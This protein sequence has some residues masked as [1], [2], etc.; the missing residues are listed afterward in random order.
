MLAVMIQS[1]E[2]VL[3]LF[4]IGFVGYV[5]DRKGW[6]SEDAKLMLPRLLTVI[7]LPPYLFHHVVKT[8]S[9]DDLIHLIYGVFVPAL[10]LALTALCAWLM[11][12]FMKKPEGRAGIFQ[13]GI[14]TSNTM[15]IGLPVNVALF[16]EAAIP[17]VLLYFF[18]NTTFF[19]TL[20]NYLIGR[21]G[22]EPRHRESI[23]SLKTL[24]RIISPPFMGL[25]LGLGSVF[26]DVRLPGF[27]MDS[28]GLI[29]GITAPLA[30]LFIGITMAGVNFRQITID[31]DVLMLL[32]GRFVISPATIILI[33]LFVDIPPLMAK[34]FIIQSSLPMVT[35]AVLL[36][37]YYRADKEY[38]TVVVS[39]TTVLTLVVIPL[40][41]MLITLLPQG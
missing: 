18:A 35:S 4:I 39:L 19:W 10:S 8:F 13:S 7:T 14:F 34:I 20:G 33:T 29:G 30:L 16:G 21:D 17:Y 38:A 5:L 28:A 22:A 25:L 27:L 23:I 36:A 24:S 12:K 31:R 41:M 40:I 1:I 6:F 32:F 9:R 3:S 2:S 37:S 26:M 11:S 15:Y